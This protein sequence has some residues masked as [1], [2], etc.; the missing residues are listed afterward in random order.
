MNFKTE[1]LER[2]EREGPLH[3]VIREDE[4]AWLVNQARNTWRM[5]AS[6]PQFLRKEHGLLFLAFLRGYTFYKDLS[7]NEQL[8]WT[9]FHQTLGLEATLP[10]PNQYDAL[11]RMFDLHPQTCGQL[12]RSGP[13]RSRREFVKTV[14]HLWGFRSLTTQELLGF[15]Q[16]YYN[17]YPGETIDEALVRRL[18]PSAEANTIRQA[19]TYDRLFRGLVQVVDHLL[20]QGVQVAL[21]SCAEVVEKLEQAGFELDTPNPVRYLYAKS[22]QALATLLGQAREGSRRRY[23]IQNTRTRLPSG[24]HSYVGATLAPGQHLEGQPVA[25]R[26]EGGTRG[27]ANLFLRLEGNATVRVL[28]GRATLAALPVGRYRA[29]LWSQYEPLGQSLEFEVLPRLTWTL[30][31]RRA[32]EPLLEGQSQVGTVTLD[33]GLFATFRWTPRWE[34]GSGGWEV[35][36]QAVSVVFETFTL[37]LELHGACYAARL[38]DV[39]DGSFPHALHG[40]EDLAH[41]T[42]KTLVPEGKAYPEVRM[43]LE[44]QPESTFSALDHLGPVFPQI[45]E[46][47]LVEMKFDGNWFRLCAL[48]FPVAL[49]LDPVVL[50]GRD[51]SVQVA[52]PSPLSLE[53]LEQATALC[54]GSQR[55]H[56]IEDLSPGWVHLRLKTPLWQGAEVTLSLRSGSDQLT[57]TT[58]CPATPTLQALLEQSLEG[59]LGWAPLVSPR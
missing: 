2:L 5:A 44:S 7:E 13:Q 14:D 45:H 42:V 53:V 56:K 1:L 43:G 59:G 30:T 58:T 36:V 39:R 20:E 6:S 18:S 40:P 24:T 27:E 51:L 11:E 10:R 25:L 15:F 35:P 22:E 54:R 4:Y 17:S 3:L 47:L 34:A 52:G 41:L 49:G 48:D 19:P 28:G 32:D 37:T 33:D 12:L 31:H 16:R 46:R 29:A 55:V 50:E 38:M 21:L 23:Q 8:F 57:R 26:V 9:Q